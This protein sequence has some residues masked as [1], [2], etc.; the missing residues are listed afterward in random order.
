MRLAR[1]VGHNIAEARQRAGLSQ[2]QFTERVEMTQQEISRMECGRHTPRLETLVK[3]ARALD[4][5]LAALLI[6]ID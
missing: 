5:P 1:E 6:G 4:V 3:V 2:M